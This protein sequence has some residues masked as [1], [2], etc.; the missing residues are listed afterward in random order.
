[1]PNMAPGTIGV[2]VGQIMAAKMGLGIIGVGVGVGTIAIAIGITTEIGE[3]IGIATM[4][5]TV[6]A[7]ATII[8][9]LI[10]IVTVVSFFHRRLTGHPAAK[11]L[12]KTAPPF[13]AGASGPWAAASPRPK[14]HPDR[15]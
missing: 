9:T 15:R 13:P 2:G 1:M 8:A 12:I 6:T 14:R 4:T 5:A 10:A 3:V 7:T 11:A